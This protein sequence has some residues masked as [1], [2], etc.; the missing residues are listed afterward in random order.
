MRRQ[1]PFILGAQTKNA[2]VPEALRVI[3]DTLA[4]YIKNG[5]SQAELTA[6][7]QNITGGFPLKISSNGSIVEYLAMIGFYGLPLDY[8]DTFVGKIESVTRAQIKDA[9]KRRL[10][11]E[12]FVTVIVGDGF[13]TPQ[14]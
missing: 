13:E 11:P 12:K 3:H 9:F 14:N 4:N 8:L 2:N 10:Q 5:P 6:A 1:G 7:K